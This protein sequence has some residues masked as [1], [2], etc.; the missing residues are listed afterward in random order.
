[1]KNS[2]AN[3]Q[4]IVLLRHRTERLTGGFL[5]P[6]EP[7]PERR[8]CRAAIGDFLDFAFAKLIVI[9]LRRLPLRRQ[10]SGLPLDERGNVAKPLAAGQFDIV[11][12]LADGFG[13]HSQLVSQSILAG[14]HGRQFLFPL[15][16][17]GLAETFGLDGEKCVRRAQPTL[18]RLQR[19]RLLGIP[20]TQ[21]FDRCEQF[22]RQAG[23]NKFLMGHAQIVEMR[24]QSL[25]FFA[26]IVRL[27][28]VFANELIEAVDVFDGDRLIEHVHRLAAHAVRLAIQPSYSTNVFVVR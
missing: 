24:Q 22:F 16:Q 2:T 6:I 28:H 12:E 20:L 15:R 4:F 5:I 9:P 25:Y 7:L 18:E 14:N 26:P 10:K 11:L 23:T 1:M 21:L 17:F 19:R 3:K 13:R 27:Q 8:E